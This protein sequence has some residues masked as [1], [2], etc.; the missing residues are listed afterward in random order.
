LAN[1]ALVAEAGSSS[2]VTSGVW[3]VAPTSSSV[4]SAPD[5]QQVPSPCGPFTSPSGALTTSNPVYFNIWNTGSEQLDGL[6]YEIS[7]SGAK[8]SPAISLTACTSPW[9]VFS[10][11]GWN[12][13]WCWGT[14][15]TVLTG[16]AEGSFPVT[17]AVPVQPGNGVYLQAALDNGRLSTLTVSTSVGPP[18]VVATTTNN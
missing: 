6:T 17:T 3:A 1:A 13:N 18:D 4:A 15:Q 11:F 2:T 8:G 9:I 12:I 7:F 14:K 16:T 5:C 10:L